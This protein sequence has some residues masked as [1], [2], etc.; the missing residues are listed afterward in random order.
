MSVQCQYS[1]STV[2]AQCQHI[3]STV[4]VLTPYTQSSRTVR[5]QPQEGATADPGGQAAAGAR[6]IERFLPKGG[7]S[8]GVAAGPCGAR[9]LRRSAVN[10]LVAGRRAF[11]AARGR[12]SGFRGGLS[13]LVP[14]RGRVRVRGPPKLVWRSVFPFSE[15][16]RR[17]CLG[18]P[19]PS[20]QVS[21]RRADHPD[22]EGVSV[23]I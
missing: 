20:S 19:G 14:W 5:V 6:R 21:S 16:H 13:R 11:G 22:L 10:W 4:L 3:P 23:D 15:G 17:G 1:A 9:C 18:P 7:R 2:P 8:R 12:T